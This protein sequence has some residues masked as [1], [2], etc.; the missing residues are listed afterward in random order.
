MRAIIQRTGRV[1]ASMLFLAVAGLAQTV[2]VPQTIAAYPEL[3]I[4][5][6]KIVTMDNPS[7]QPNVGRTVEAMVVRQGKV[8]ALGTNAEILA[9]AG[10]QTRRLDARG[11][12]VIPGLINTHSHM[13]DHSIRLWTR[14]NRD[15]VEEVQRSFSVTGRDYAEIKKGIELVVKE[16]MARAR[17]GQWAYIELP[18]G[19]SSGT[20]IGVKFLGDQGLSREELDEW[21]PQTP[22]FLNSHPAWMLN[23]AAEVSFLNLYGLDWDEETVDKALTMNTTIRRSLV[24]DRYFAPRIG[25]MADLLKGGLEHQAALGLTT[26]SSHIVGLRIHDAYMKMVRDGTMPIRFGFAHRFCQQVEPEMA[27]C[28]MRLGDMEGLGND[29][30]FNVGVTLGGI[31]TGPPNICTSM[32]APPEYKSKEKCI[33]EPGSEYE[34]AIAAAISSYQ[35]YVVNHVYGDKAL[36]TFMDIVDRQIENTPGITL[37]YIKE[38]RLTSD[39]CGFY[40]RQEQLPRLKRLGMVVSCDP[41]FMD[42][43]YPWLKVYGEDKANRI[44]PAASLVKNGIMVTAEAEVDVE[45]GTGPTYFAVQSHFMTRKNSRGEPV[46][47]EEAVDRVT[48]M[49]MMTT[50]PSFYLKKE[51]ELGSLEVGKFADFVILNKDYFTIPETEIP[52]AFPLA[53]ILGGKTIVLRKELADEW[54]TQPVGP[55][56]NWEFATKFTAEGGGE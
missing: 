43:S 23:K 44:G 52:T 39:H 7:F 37:D 19:G 29:Y 6:A 40:P 17:P 47:P 34:K 13:H 49:K 12:T 24:V 53:T 28:F 51:K 54:G 38:R 56:M 27:G 41:M 20:G 21:A 3:I 46:A 2:T 15:K 36:D 32:D 1:L 42:R 9:L 8:Q 4:H 11:R 30:F 33:L 55:Q 35:R 18:N 48:L 45:T 5:N 26:F 22:V 25:E 14:Q 16:Q 50:W 31:D 10:P